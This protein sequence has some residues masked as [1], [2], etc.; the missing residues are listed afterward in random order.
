MRTSVVNH[1]GKD[2]N[3]HDDEGTDGLDHQSE[4]WIMMVQMGLSMIRIRP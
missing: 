1:V 4:D 2:G 3:N